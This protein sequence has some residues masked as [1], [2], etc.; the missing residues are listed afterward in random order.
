MSLL[1][2]DL[3]QNLCCLLY[4]AKSVGLITLDLSQIPLDPVIEL[5]QKIMILIILE[6]FFILEQ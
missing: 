3:V 6:D 5:P 2:L 1:S 4:L